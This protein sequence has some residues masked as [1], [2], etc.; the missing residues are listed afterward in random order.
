M[1]EI[2]NLNPKLRVL[3]MTSMYN[4]KWIN[5]KKPQ[6]IKHPFLLFDSDNI[7][8]IILIWHKTKELN[9]P[10]LYISEV[11]L[12]TTIIMQ[13]IRFPLL[14]NCTHL[15]IGSLQNYIIAANTEYAISETQISQTFLLH[16]QKPGIPPPY[17]H[18]YD[19]ILT[20]I[21][22]ELFELLK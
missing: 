2:T 16:L 3:Y 17:T 8:K 15:Y 20:M 4:Y 18:T 9:S 10:Y 19:I 14:A 11:S 7:D 1:A 22:L 5:W 6:F 12:N 13:N 21:K